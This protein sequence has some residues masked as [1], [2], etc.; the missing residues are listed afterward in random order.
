MSKVLLIVFLIF[1]TVVGSGFSSG[2]EI[3]VY[4]SRFGSMSY[5]YIL[6]AGVLFFFLFYFFLSFGSKMSQ[7]L[8]S[9][10][11]LNAIVVFISLIFCSS[12]FAGVKNLFSYFPIWIYVVLLSF[13]ILLCVLVTK[14]GMRGLEKANL[15]LIPVVSVLFLAVLI[16]C[17]TKTSDFSLSA[18]SF[19]GFLF[20]PLYVTLNTSMSGL[21]I[22]KV[23]E[24]L[25]KKQTF[26]ACL[27]STILILIF[28]F[29][30][31]FV[32]RKN[33][34]SFFS[35]MPF[36]FLASSNK[37]MFAMCFVVILVGCFTTLLSLCFTLKTA[38]DKLCKS[39]TISTI[40][41]VILPF[42]VSSL[43]FSHI[44]SFLYPICSVLGVFVLGFLLIGAALQKRQQ[45]EF[46]PLP[47]EEQ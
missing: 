20:C 38:F 39:E 14:R 9:S 30:G 26:F 17:G 36:L 23:G 15:F 10:R 2:K 35:E 44:V 31:N 5:F 8:K 16:F 34:N 18:S 1:G 40:F 41:A 32:L 11:L 4:F 12:M 3:F 21:V 22:A 33:A 47:R 43:G 7:I 29:L 6:L 46:Q 37:L 27:L 13:V 24:G 45:K 28:L 42:C 19:A 25:S